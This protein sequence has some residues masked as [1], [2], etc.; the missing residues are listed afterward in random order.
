MIPR[1][2]LVFRPAAH[3]V[4]V[5]KKNEILLLKTK[6]TGRYWFPGGGVE[7][8][9]RVEEG[10][11]REVREEAGI[12]I[13]VEELLTFKE[14][15]FY[16]EPLDAAYH[17]LAFYYNCKPKTAELLPD[18]Q[19]DQEDECEKPRWV[20]LESLKREEMQFGAEEIFDLIEA[21]FKTES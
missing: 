14:A 10:M 8:G 18:D 16:Y 9:E 13:E 17:N 3:A 11:K 21:R 1:E 19:V 7:L 15:F 4:V 20:K 2:K 6:T 5:N 12:E